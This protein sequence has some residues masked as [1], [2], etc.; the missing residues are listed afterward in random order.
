[1]KHVIKVF[2]F[3]IFFSTTLSFAQG[4]E[5]IK[6]DVEKETE[7]VNQAEDKRVYKIDKVVPDAK[8]SPEKL[9]TTIDANKDSKIDIDEA[10]LS[11]N[12]KISEN[13]DKI[14]TNR[15]GFIDLAELKAKMAKKK[16]IKMKPKSEYND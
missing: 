14:D 7:N 9:L 2:A 12:K 16:D 4:A 3:M 8:L 13:F 6:K 11:G 1:M 5:P 15:D 10:S